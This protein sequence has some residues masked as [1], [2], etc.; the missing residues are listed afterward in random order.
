MNFAAVIVIITRSLAD[1]CDRD[2]R[3]T[4]SLP[5]SR[6]LV[7]PFGPSFGRFRSV[8][9][10]EHDSSSLPPISEGHE[11]RSRRLRL[12]QVGRRSRGPLQY[13][14]SLD[15]GSKSVVAVTFSI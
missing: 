15:H 14:P 1:C 11:Q 4:E 7:F 2:D 9:G 8:G 12:E 3:L 6:R 13:A 10:E 5:P